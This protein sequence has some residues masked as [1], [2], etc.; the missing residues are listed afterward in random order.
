[1]HR[2]TIVGIVGAVVLVGVMVAVFVYEYGQADTT[3]DGTEQERDF[4]RLF[5][6]L[7]ATEDLD[8]D[9]TA[10]AEDDDMDDDGVSD[11]NDTAIAVHGDFSGT[12]AQGAS[13]PPY[14]T[15]V[16]VGTG[17]VH[18][19]VYVNYSLPAP[20][21][22]G[23]TFAL[24]ARLLDA[25]GASVGESEATMPATG[26][27]AASIQLELSDVVAGNYTVEVTRASPSTATAFTGAYDVH[28]HFERDDPLLEK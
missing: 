1:M 25:D 13:P 15:Q 26:Q 17:A 2:D 20:A 16:Y 22:V 12:I 27:S 23:N 14:T 9:G 6:G 21:P 11:L 8:G 18:L 19:V 10:N 3:G 28:Y 4:A 5:Q 7:N 24:V